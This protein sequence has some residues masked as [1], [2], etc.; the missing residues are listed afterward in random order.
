MEAIHQKI[1]STC[2]TEFDLVRRYYAVL[3]ELNDIKI[4]N[5]QLNLIAYCAI[6][7]TISTPP[8]R[9]EF[10]RLFNVP[11]HSLYNMSGVLTKK[12]IFVKG[13]DK[14]IRVNPAILPNFKADAIILTIKL[15]IN[16]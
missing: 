5:N 12:G 1:L 9:D 8:V 11:K 4:T 16:G 14:K 13:E 15:T 3:F 10:R 6:N 2:E 7:G